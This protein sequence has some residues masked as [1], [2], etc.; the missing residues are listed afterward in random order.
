MPL[1]APL[2]PSPASSFVGDWRRSSSTDRKG[3]G[4]GTR[5]QSETQNEYICRTPSHNRWTSMIMTIMIMMVMRNDQ[6]HNKEP[7]DGGSDYN[8]FSLLPERQDTESVGVYATQRKAEWAA[9]KYVE[10]HLFFG[11][12]ADNEDGEDQTWGVDWMGDGWFG[13]ACCDVNRV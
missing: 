10:E 3:V 11:D 13:N 9:R 1:P 2:S 5:A 8:Y 4:L 12:D 7:Q 6:D